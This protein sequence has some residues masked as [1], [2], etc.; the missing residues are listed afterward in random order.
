MVFRAGYSMP[1]IFVVF[2]LRK[3][4]HGHSEAKEASPDHLESSPWRTE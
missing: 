1:D 2:A 3:M 4:F